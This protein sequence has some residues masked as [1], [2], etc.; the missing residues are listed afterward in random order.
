MAG[1]GRNVQTEMMNVTQ[2]DELKPYVA[3][4]V[5]SSP[6]VHSGMDLQDTD[7]RES[8]EEKLSALGS[9]VNRRGLSQ[10]TLEDLDRRTC[11]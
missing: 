8:D 6:T 1:R 3:G 5:T 9:P 10:I 2:A 11:Q 4:A 7:K